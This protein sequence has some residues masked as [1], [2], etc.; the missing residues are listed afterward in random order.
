M[1]RQ[2]ARVVFYELI[3]GIL[4]LAVIA[5]AFFAWRLSQGP[6]ELGAFRDDIAAALTEARDGREVTLETVQLEWS[7]ERR[8]VDVA[9]RGLVFYSAT[10]QP[11]AHAARAD[12]ELDAS[13]LLL[14]EVEVVS[15]NL[16]QAELTIQQVSPDVW[17]VGGEP[18]PPIPQGTA[19]QTGSAWIQRINR[20]LSTTLRQ[21]AN[22]VE[23]LRL[24][25][26][27]F[28][29]LTID[30]EAMSGERLIRLDGARGRLERIGDDL[31][32]SL[33]ARGGGNGVPGGVALRVT[34]SDSFAALDVELAFAAWTLAEFGQRLGLSPDRLNGLPADIALTFAATRADGL[35][36]LDVEL[37][38]G[39]GAIAVAGQPVPVSR[40]DGAASYSTEADTLDFYFDTID[41]GIVRGEVSGR[42]EAALHGE[43]DRRLTLSSPDLRVDTTPYF[44][45]AWRFTPVE[46][47]A[48]IDPGLHAFE[49]SQASLGV[50]GATVRASGRMARNLDQQ[51]GELPFSATIVAEMSGRAGTRTVLDF[52]PVD[53]GRGAR[54][55]VRDNIAAGT[56]TGATARLDL[57]VDSFR[58]GYLADEALQVDF[59]VAGAQ[60]RFLSDVAPVSGASGTGRLTGNSF[61]VNLAEGRWQNWAIS[62]GGVELAQINP[63]GGDMVIVAE[64][65]GPVR[66]AVSA[67]F[68]SRLDL[69]ARTGFDPDRLSGT[70]EV[71]FEMHRPALS[72]V[73]LEDMTITVSGRARDAGL[74]QAAGGLD[75]ADASARI[76]FDLDRLSVSGFGR[77]G[78]AEVTFDWRDRFDDAGAPSELA[79]RSTVTPDILNRFGF[80]GR[81]YIVGEVPTEMTAQI[82]GNTVLNASVDL[83]LAGVRIDLAE[84]GWLKPAGTPATA[85]VDYVREG[86]GFRAAGQLDSALAKLSGEMLLGE[87]GR[88]IEL[89][90]D[91]A[92]LSGRADVSGEV[93]RG[94]DGGLAFSLRGPFLDV[95]NAIPDLGSLGSAGAMRSAITMD[96]EVDRLALGNGLQLA[97]ARLAAISTGEG[98]QSFVVAGRFSDTASM[99][100][101]YRRSAPGLAELS[102]QSDDAGQLVTALL[103]TDVLVGGQLNMTGTLRAGN[104]ASDLL[105][106]IDDSRLRNAPFLTQIL[107]LAS[108][109]GLADTLGGDGVLF[110]EIEL[111]LQMAGGRYVVRGGRASGPALGLT[112]N[113]W[114]EPDEGGISVDGVLVPSFGVNSALGGVPIIGDLFVGRE[115]EGVFS[116]TY[117]VRGELAKAQVQVNPL[118]AIT[119]G[120]LRRIFENPTDTDLPLPDE[121]LPGE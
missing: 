62:D 49:V 74:A 118:S 115:G 95:S 69:E 121:T 55:F 64:G 76:D 105:I 43:G 45:R 100:A 59:T 82:D 6:M 36:R 77:L 63:K 13:A 21:G 7:P 72:D 29:D 81:P 37:E 34:S 113:G 44:E 106:R 79:V 66:E 39:A 18:L 119:P 60:V 90:L 50:D 67:I 61:S 101:S 84:I 107:S 70:G 25:A 117:S 17:S 32:F 103:D 14:G 109:R 94:S 92:Y 35:K 8:R 58:A 26:V 71:R 31:S 65:T 78:P 40:L 99:E 10:G 93:R 9:A 114:V 112:V 97:G 86:E 52:W 111:P 47:E 54:H 116:L 11:S 4:F 2:T 68:R 28:E 98:L 30:L 110:S 23:G 104:V 15:L 88:L 16:S 102:V 89:D 24:E 46:I 87:D 12:I 3:G 73:P 20:L 51:E 57:D 83:D 42:V 41:A 48:F 33:A 80:L 96:A 19:P 108:L 27:A 56:L 120:V 1:V 53:L 85:H 75:L 38:T 22:V 91:R 5:A